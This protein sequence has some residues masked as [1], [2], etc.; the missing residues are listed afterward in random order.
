MPSHR[1][2]YVC[3]F[4]LVGGGAHDLQERLLPACTV[5]PITRTADSND[6]S[7]PVAVTES[8]LLRAAETPSTLGTVAALMPD[9][10][11][12]RSTLTDGRKLSERPPAATCALQRFI[13]SS[14]RTMYFIIGGA[15]LIIR[16]IS[17]TDVFAAKRTMN[18]LLQRSLLRPTPTFYLPT[19]T[20]CVHSVSSTQHVCQRLVVHPVRT[21]SIS[22]RFIH[23]NR[24]QPAPPHHHRRQDRHLQP[25]RGQRKPPCCGAA[26]APTPTC[27]RLR[28]QRHQVGCT[29]RGTETPVSVI[30]Q[31]ASGG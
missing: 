20:R 3:A 2:H 18:Y 10:P 29:A 25:R 23:N 19:S 1:R 9:I 4:S 17:T 31:Y 30:K 13:S 15:I 22:T 5:W 26:A 16:S 12:E 27:W 24:H 6:D 28:A 11:L 21:G 7:S 8:M 14:T